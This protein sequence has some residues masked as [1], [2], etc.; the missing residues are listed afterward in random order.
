MNNILWIGQCVVALAFV[1]SG[2]MKIVVPRE[3]LL[4]KMKFF[5]SWSRV[6]I[7]L[8]GTAELLGGMG[9]VAPGAV[10]ILPALT[11]VAAICLAI[12]M[13]GAIKTHVDLGERPVAPAVLGAMALLIALG[14]FAVVPV[15]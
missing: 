4:A 15:Q 10:H 1:A 3:K 12:L 13:G 6:T 11:P 8:L 2:I 9:L 14:R 5:A 7:K